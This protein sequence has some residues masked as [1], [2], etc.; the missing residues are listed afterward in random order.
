[1]PRPT[2]TGS[3]RLAATSRVKATQEGMRAKLPCLCGRVD[4]GIRMLGARYYDAHA[5]LIIRKFFY[6]IPAF[7]G[8]TAGAGMT[9]GADLKSVP[10]APGQ[11]RWR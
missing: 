11:I 1:M 9:E 5:P 2:M 8:M 7:A 10:G 4:S 3:S 6:W